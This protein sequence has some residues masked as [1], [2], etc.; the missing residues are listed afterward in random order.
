[1][2]ACCN[3]NCKPNFVNESEAKVCS[4]DIGNISTWVKLTFLVIIVS[5]ENQGIASVEFVYREG[6]WPESLP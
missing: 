6:C 1:M 5:H 3:C 4:K 2:R